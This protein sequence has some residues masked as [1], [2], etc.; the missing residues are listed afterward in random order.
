MVK[1]LILFTQILIKLLEQYEVG[2]TMYNNLP[3]MVW[4]ID[5][6]REITL[7]REGL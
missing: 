7:N 1:D 3:T 4:N 2:V 5:Y 6:G